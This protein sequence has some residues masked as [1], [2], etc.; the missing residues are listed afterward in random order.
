[1]IVTS[2]VLT[3][4]LLAGMPKA[5]AAAGNQERTLLRGIDAFTNQRFEE[6]VHA[7][8]HLTQ[9]GIRNGYLFYNLGNAYLKHEQLGP[10]IYWYERALP[11]L[12]TQADLRF[13]L[14]YARSLCVDDKPETGGWYRVLFFWEHLL[15]SQTIQY[16]CI[17]L[18]LLV[19]LGLGIR[20]IRPSQTMTLLTLGAMLILIT[21]LPSAIRQ[22]LGPVIAPRAI[23]LPET[24]LVRSGRSPKATTLFQLHA[25]TSVRVEEQRQDYVKIR[26]RPAMFGWMARND[27][28]IL[29]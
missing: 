24:A 4:L 21:L 18:N 14:D 3:I 15:A 27:L 26:F 23:V 8:H 11:F 12:P 7:F 5:Y 28:G 17:G 6:A 22:T 20:L 13:N 19:C 1:M 9:A 29:D 2:S 10:A 25:G 16:L